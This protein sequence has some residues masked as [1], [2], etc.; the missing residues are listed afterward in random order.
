MTT[1]LDLNNFMV[2]GKFFL[3]IAGELIVIFIAVAFI[4]GLLLEYLPPS[5]IRGF[6][7][8]RLIGV[9]Y[10]LG[11]G[12][13]AITPFCSCSTVPVLTGLLRGGVPFGPVMAFLFSS[14]VLNPV[15]IG[16]FLMLLGWKVTAVYAVVTFL[17][18]ML[19]AAILS[20]LGFERD[21]KTVASFQGGCGCAAKPAVDPVAAYAASVEGGCAC[22]DDDAESPAPTT[23][24]CSSTADAAGSEDTSFKA[25]MR[26]AMASAVGTFKGVFWYLM[27]GAGIGAFIYGFFPQDLVSRLAGPGN[28]WS[29]PI[30]A[31]LGVPMYIRAETAIPIGAALIGKGMGVGT[32]LALVVAG[33][34]ASIPEFIILSSI[35]KRRLVVA[36]VVTVFVVAL[37]AGY[38]VDLLG[39]VPYIPGTVG[40]K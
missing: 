8:G 11:A 17:G 34:G 24:C 16:L 4:V 36:F 38:V 33:A 19:V 40:A 15:I 3:I 39:I 20:R 23:S 18:A 10:F 14:P 25:R 1:Y 35:F 5:R 2:A 28:P 31:A 7:A 22:G 37:L 29:I 9:Q 26:R 27:I 32:I 6:L 12:L 13:G 21:I 30:A